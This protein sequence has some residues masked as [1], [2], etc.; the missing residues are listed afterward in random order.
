[1]SEPCI[2]PICGFDFTEAGITRIGDSWPGVRAPAEGFRWL[3]FDL[4]EESLTRWTNQ[5]L[6][7]IAA[8][9]LVQRV[10]RPR[11][12]TMAD[13]LILNLR[14]VNVNPGTDPEDMLSLRFWIAPGTL[15]SVQAGP[16]RAIDTMRERAERGDAP[17]DLGTFLATLNHEITRRIETVSLA[18]EE[19][20]D[21]TEEAML[22]GDRPTTGSIGRSRQMSIKLRRY[23]NPQR[24]ALDTLASEGTP[25]LG[26]PACQLTRETANRTRRALEEIDTARDRLGALQD[27]IDAQQAQALARNSYL[28]SIIA[29][30]FLPLGFLT[31][32]FG[33]NVGG[34]PG[35]NTPAAFW[36]LATASAGLGL[37]VYLL[38]K[39]SRWL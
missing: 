30:I 33:V 28:L 38:L 23:L 25:I 29:A 19:S 3:H 31:G 22:N 36:I 5:T 15:V 12:E 27:H 4:S 37:V 7:L 10:T 26:L 35:I 34:M 13:G 1:M 21:D 39:I 9:A 18:L 2:T 24:E 6:P 11:C 14:A 8:G 32:L 20:V 17:R 16:I